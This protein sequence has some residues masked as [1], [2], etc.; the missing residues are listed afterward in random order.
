MT[1]SFK[2]FIS[3]GVND[4][5][6]FKAVFLAGGPGSGKS[7]MVGKTAL[8]TFGLRPINSD[9]VFEAALR[10]AEMAPT[11]ENIYSEKG[12]SIRKQAKYL[13][14]KKLSLSVIGRLGLVIDGT[15]KDVA[16]IQR[17]MTT[18]KNIGYDVAMIF[19]NTDI[20][21]ALERNK[22]RAR[23]LPDNIVKKM[24]N[25]V[26]NNIG[27]FQRMFR[28]EMIIVDNSSDSNVESNTL[29]A[30]RQIQ[31]FVRAPVRNHKAREWITNAQK[32][33]M[34]E[35]AVEQLELIEKLKAS[36]SMG[37]WI[38]DFY[39][40]DAPQFKGKSKAKRRQMA[41]AAKLDA[42]EEK[43]EVPQDKDIAKRKGSQP[44]KYHKGLSKSTK[45]A[46]DAQFKRQAKM[47]DSDPKAYKPAPGDKTA[48]TKPS[49]YTK[50]VDNLLNKEEA[51]DEKCW[52]SHK[53]VGMKKKGDKM[54]PNCVPKN[55]EAEERDSMT[56]PQIGKLRNVKKR[57]SKQRTKTKQFD[58]IK[59][60][61]EIELQEIS[62]SDK[63][64]AKT[65]Y[66]DKYE[67]FAKLL[68]SKMRKDRL[69]H[70]GKLRHGAY[71]H[72]HELLRLYRDGK[73]LNSKILGD[74]V[75][76]SFEEEYKYEW[77][78]PEG[79]EHMKS[80]TPGETPKKKKKE[81]TNESIYKS[82][83]HARLQKH[84]DKI[85]QTAKYKAD[86]RK[87]GGTPEKP[88]SQN[89]FVPTKKEE[90]NEEDGKQCGD[91]MYY[92][93]QRK[94]CVAIPEG[95]KDR[96]DGFIVRENVQDVLADIKK[97]WELADHSKPEIGEPMDFTLTD[98]DIQD[99]MNQADHLTIDDMVELGMYSPDEIETF[100]I[101]PDD[102]HSDVEVTEALTPL[103]RIKRRQAARRNK[104]RLKVARAR[105]MRKSAT[106]DKIKMRAT[107]GARGMMYK[108]L[109]R[110]RDK[111]SLPPAE[112]S[113][114]EKMIQRFQPLIARIA[115]RMVP[116]MRKAELNRLKKRGAMTSQKAKKFVVK[117]GGS[118]SKYKA[119]KF[120]IKK[121]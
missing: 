78:T 4:P 16:K 51:I 104:Q 119:K 57:V 82:P 43:T 108:R 83:A 84:M 80:V 109:L 72:A 70:G 40:S 23:T 116:Q 79:T 11:P 95:Y 96:G 71:Y 73:K 120:K 17:Q 66:K 94:A 41:I 92:C 86:V 15:G 14:Q 65:V 45:K 13:T 31:Q 117:K 62:M 59:I 75:K 103:G 26:Q 44:A 110:G 111:S 60:D 54:V 18:L 102:V 77:G 87:L 101:D 38:D 3:E 55:E 33:K 50:Y 105:A 34:R 113:R 93:R 68:V 100:E 81:E 6:I 61:E 48:K 10:K 99:M 32:Q 89:M 5:G 28:N 121:K 27:A 22:A 36:D 98:E 9:D 67:K 30:Y 58:K 112:K 35:E 42:M 90:V 63:I 46:R 53:Q 114:L 8:S 118:A 25:D 47:S 29:S 69:M 74:M 12:Q 24:W 37:D 85:R 97:F 19:V 7:F 56:L 115:V 49:K 106:P 1:E 52:D 39:K 107:R 76:E 64:K 21:T 91:G 88:G 20:E 2:E